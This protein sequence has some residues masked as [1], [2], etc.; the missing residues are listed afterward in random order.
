MI[1]LYQFDFSPYCIKIRALLNAKDLEYRTVEILP[2]VTQY[3][4]KRVSGQSQV[5]VLC[6][7][8]EVVSDSTAIALYLEATYPDPPM[9]PSSGPERVQVLLWEDWADEV[10]SL[11]IRPL[12]LEAV[13]H[14][15][16]AGAD[17]IPPYGN[18]ALDLLVPRLSPVI[19]RMLLRRYGLA[20]VARRA[21]PKLDRALSLVADAVGDR[22]HLV[23][24]A[25]T[26]ADIAV[27]TAAKPLDTLRDI[28]RDPRWEAFFRW[29][30]GVLDRCFVH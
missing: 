20:G 21:A 24:D 5:P 18:L 30:D 12:A 3:R 6:D 13:A 26:L 23:G 15:R 8:G 22:Q 28:R 17:Q 14:D 7:A 25:L 9:I 27:A 4:V 29:R 1:E 11:L 10:L 16:S 2:F 19:S